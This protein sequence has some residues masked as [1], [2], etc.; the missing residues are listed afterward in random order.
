MLFLQPSIWFLWLIKRLIWIM[1]ANLE[2]LLYVRRH[3]R[4]PVLCPLGSHTTRVFYTLMNPVLQRLIYEIFVVC[5]YEVT[6]A[7]SASAQCVRTA[8]FQHEM[9]RKINFL[10]HQVMISGM[11]EHP[12]GVGN[13]PTWN[14][15][16][17]WEM[18]DNEQGMKPCQFHQTDFMGRRHK[19][20]S[21]T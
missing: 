2:L 14:I 12:A 18:L 3:H 17:C 16:R 4:I 21:S 19:A 5:F 6:L 15:L 8:E 1:T 7:L 9:P 10:C 13:V 11:T 20:E